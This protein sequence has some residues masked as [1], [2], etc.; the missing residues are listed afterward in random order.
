MRRAASG[1]D[2][3]SFVAE[4]EAALKTELRSLGSLGSRFLPDPLRPVLPVPAPVRSGDPALRFSLLASRLG[5][6]GLGLGAVLD[7][8]EEEG[9]GKGA[10]DDT[11]SLT[12][13]GEDDAALPLS[14][15]WNT[16]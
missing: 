14:L 6:L 12:G 7:I 11:C 9:K 1:E 16:R 5:G 3:T 15:G 2:T 10:G 4:A 8:S 13:T